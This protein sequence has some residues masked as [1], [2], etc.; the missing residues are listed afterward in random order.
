MEDFAKIDNYSTPTTHR[1]AL[2]DRLALNTNAYFAPQFISQLLSNRKLA[3]KGN[4]TTEMWANKSLD[5]LRLIEN[6]GGHFHIE[7]MNNISVIKEPVIFISNHMSMLESM[8]LPGLIAPRREVTFVVK[9]SLVNHKLFG[10]VM[11]ARNPICVERQ[12]PIA[13]FKKVMEEGPKKIEAGTS[14]VVFPQ[15]KRNVVFDPEQFNT[16]GVKLA[17][18]TKAAI[19][20]IALKTDFWKNGKYVKDIGGLNRKLEIHFK[21][22]SPI[23]I[24]GNG[25]QEHQQ[26]I[27]FIQGELGR[28]GT[29]V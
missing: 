12:N 16:L 14:I 5:I 26:I 27:E 28:W 6:C 17:K 23:Y 19:I 10:P 29:S 7:N 3:Q 20:P 24:E 9:E 22:G 15:S 21:F 1:R 8:V 2:G 4:Y 25:K 11:R 13:D 18:K